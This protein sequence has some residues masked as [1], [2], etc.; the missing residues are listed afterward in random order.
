MWLSQAYHTPSTELLLPSGRHSIAASHIIYLS[1][2]SYEHYPVTRRVAAQRGHSF[3]ITDQRPRQTWRAK[4][5]SLVWKS[6]LAWLERL[7][8]F[9]AVAAAAWS[10]YWIH[11]AWREG[12]RAHYSNDAVLV[13]AAGIRVAHGAVAG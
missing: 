11:A 8:D 12:S 13:T 7:L 9:L 5:P 6:L 2:I 3:S 1:L 4:N 10:S